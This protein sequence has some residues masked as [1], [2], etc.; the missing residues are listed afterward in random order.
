MNPAR[1]SGI[2]W[3]L[4]SLCRTPQA[5]DAAFTRQLFQLH[6]DHPLLSRPR[7]R[8]GGGALNAD[9]GFVIRHFAAEVEYTA[10]GV[11]PAGFQ[12]SPPAGSSRNLVLCSSRVGTPWNDTLRARI[13]RAYS[14]R[15][16]TSRN[17]RRN[18]SALSSPLRRLSRAR[19]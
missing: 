5:T 9:E 19:C 3:I 8:R 13:P 17:S 7:A 2:F 1:D 15:R 10:A 18:S 16:R 4:D 12:F 6:G 11:S 14:L